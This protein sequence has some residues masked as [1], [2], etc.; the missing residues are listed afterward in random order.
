MCV[1]I[2]LPVIVSGERYAVMDPLEMVWPGETGRWWKLSELSRKRNAL[3]G[4]LG[5]CNFSLGCHNFSDKTLFRFPLR[6][7]RSKLS[8]VNYTL[9]KLWNTLEALRKE[10]KY[11]LLFLRSV[12]TIGVYK[13]TPSGEEEV[14]SVSITEK[15]W[16]RRHDELRQFEEKIKYQFLGRQLAHKVREVIPFTSQFRVV[17]AEQG[18]TEREYEWLVVQQ[19]GSTSEKVLDMVRLFNDRGESVLPWVG[20]AIELSE[21]DQGLKSSRIFCFLP[22]PFEKLSP[23]PVHVNGSFAISK[24]RRSLKW[25]TVERQTDPGAQWNELLTTH[26]LSSCYKQLLVSLTLNKTT[27]LSV[28]Y[29]AWPD[30]SVVNE[31]EW[32][33]L[34][35]PLFSALL[36]EH[37]F[38]SVAEGGQWIKLPDAWLTP[39]NGLPET[40]KSCL[41]ACN[42]KLV[43]TNPLIW[44][45]F[46]FCPLVLIQCISPSFVREVLRLNPGLNSMLDHQQK[47][48]ILL[49]CMSDDDYSGIRG[50]ELLPLA[51]NTFQNFEERDWTDDDDVYLCTSEFPSLLL[52]FLDDRL[53]DVVSFDD[54]QAHFVKLA[55]SGCTQVV[56]VT[57]QSIA[58]LLPQSIANGWSLTNY[59]FFWN[60]IQ[61]H[62][63]DNI[64]ACPV[65]PLIDDSCVITEAISLCSQPKLVFITE[66]DACRLK[67]ELLSAFKKM[68]VM[69]VRQDKLR[70]LYHCEI[71]KY[72]NSLTPDGVL[73]STNFSANIFFTDT[74]SD[75]LL[76]FLASSNISNSSIEVLCRLPIFCTLQ[77]GNNTFFSMNRIADG[78][79]FA[80]AEDNSSPFVI[81]VNLLPIKPLVIAQRA[82]S[83]NTRLLSQLKA[84][85]K[86]SLITLTDFSCKYVFPLIR[87][88]QFPYSKLN[89]FMIVV[90]ELLFYAFSESDRNKMLAEM[91][92]VPFLLNASSVL[93]CP[94]ELFDCNCETAESL[95]KG[96]PVFPMAP[97]DANK[98]SH[99]LRIA[100]LKCEQDVTALNI[101]EIVDQIKCSAVVPQNRGTNKYAR[102]CSV[103]KF[104]SEK[105]SILDERPNRYYYSNDT[106]F[107]D[108]TR[109]YHTTSWLPVCSTP[110]TDYP[111]CLSWKGSLYPNC[112]ASQAAGIAPL[113]QKLPLIA[114]SQLL[115]IQDAARDK[116]TLELRPPKDALVQAVIRHFNEVIRNCLDIDW[117]VREKI[118]NW[119][120]TYLRDNG[121]HT[122]IYF[123]NKKWIWLE[124]RCEFV[125]SRRV[126]LR[127]N[128]NFSS[129]LEPFITILSVK[130]EQFHNLFEKFGV[131]REITIQQILSVLKMIKE[132]AVAEVF[133]TQAWQMVTDILYWVADNSDDIDIEE[134]LVPVQSTNHYP[135]LMPI[136][137]VAYID[138][139]FVMTAATCQLKPCSIVNQRIPSD[140]SKKLRVKPLSE[141]LG[142]S[143]ELPQDVGQQEPLL[144]RLKNILKDYKDGLTIIKELLQNADDAEAT[145]LNIIYD[146]RNHESDLLLFPGMAKAH[147]PAL[148]VH[149]DRTFAEE[150]FENITKLA[151]ATKRDKP[152][153]IGKFGV[154]FCSVYH[155]TDV[156]SF[157][158]GE[159][160]YIFDPTLKHLTVKNPAQ[161]GKKIQ[162][163]STLLSG[164]QQLNP[165]RSIFNYSPGYSYNGTI[166]RLPFRS[167]ESEL[168]SK[169][170]NESDILSLKEQLT[171]EGSK[172]LLFLRHVK[173]ITFSEW[174]QDEQ[175]PQQL[176]IIHKTDGLRILENVQQVKVRINLNIE[177]WLV[178]SCLSKHD[179]RNT[180]QCAAV[181]CKL[182]SDDGCPQVCGES[183]CSLPLGFQTGL[184]VHVSANFAVTSN[185]REIWSS[186]LED[187][188]EDES[189]WNRELMRS[190][191]PDAYS[192]L[193]I[194]LKDLALDEHEISLD[195]YSFHS[196]WPLKEHLQHVNPWYILID[197]LY[198]RISTHALFYSQSKHRWF[199]LSDCTFICPKIFGKLLCETPKCVSRGLEILGEPIVDLPEKFHHYIPE[200]N[201]ISESEFINTFL[202]RIFSF[203]SHSDIRDEII[204]QVLELYAWHAERKIPFN[205]DILAS[206]ACIPCTPNGSLKLCKDL[207]DPTS[208][209]A[210]LFKPKDGF[211]PIKILCDSQPAMRAMRI[212]GLQIETVSYEALAN[213]ARQI[214]S[215]YH[216]KKEKALRNLKL[217]LNCVEKQIEFNHATSSTKR[218]ILKNVPFLPVMQKPENYVLPVWYGEIM[219]FQSPCNLMYG[220]KLPDLVGSQVAIVDAEI[221]QSHDDVLSHIGVKTQ[222][223]VS[224]V[225]TQLRCL[226]E[227]DL[228]T[229]DKD[230]IG[231]TYTTICDFLQKKEEEA[232]FDDEKLD[233][234][235][236]NTLPCVWTGQLFVKP[237]C[238]AK[239]WKCDGPILHPVPKALITKPAL[240]E[241]LGCKDSFSIADLLNALSLL[242]KADCSI[243]LNDKRQE[244]VRE[245]VAD[246]DKFE[247]DEFEMHNE[248]DDL[249]LPD[250]SFVMCKVSDLVFNDVEWDSDNIRIVHGCVT[251]SLAKKL[252]VVFI[253]NKVLRSSE[254]KKF[255]GLPFGQREILQRRI[256]SILRQY[257]FDVTFMKEI[258]QNA[259][260]AKA[261]KLC[262]I[263]DK[264]QLVSRKSEM[265]SDSWKELQG[266]ALLLW[267]NSTFTDKDLQGIQ[268]LGTGGKRGDSD[269][270]GQ[271][272]IG[273]SVVYHVTD[274][275]SIVTSV[276]GV[277][278]LCV[279][280]P[281]CK[282]V[283]EADVLNPGRRYEIGE[284]F[285]KQFPVMKQGYDIDTLDGCPDIMKEQLW[286]GSLFRLPIRKTSEIEDSKSD[287]SIFTEFTADVITT[288]YLLDHIEQWIEDVKLSLLFLNHLTDIEF[289]VINE[290][291]KPQMTLLARHSTTLTE[292]ARKCRNDLECAVNS[293]VSSSSTPKV[294]LYQIYL[295][296]FV[297]TSSPAEE[298][299]ECWLVQ[300]GVG[301]ICL[302]NHQWNFLPNF[303]P[304]HGLAAPLQPGKSKGQVFCFLPLPCSFGLPV[305]INGQFMLGDTRRQLW[306]P[307]DPNRPDDR[308]TWN[309]HL[310]EA[311]GSSYAQF[312]QD[313]IPFFVK[314]CYENYKAAK[315]GLKGYYRIFPT[316][317]HSKS[318]MKKKVLDTVCQQNAKILCS[319]KEESSG[320]QYVTE[321]APIKDEDELNQSYMF[322]AF[323]EPPMAEESELSKEDLK[324]RNEE[325]SKMK[326]QHD[327]LRFLLAKIGMNIN[328]VPSYICRALEIPVANGLEVLKFCKSFPEKIGALPCP[329]EETAISSVG[330]FAA[331]LE[332]V[333]I[334][335]DQHLHVQFV[336][337]HV[338]APFLLTAD[339]HLQLFI[340][341]HR[342]IFCKHLKLF[343]NCSVT[344]HFAHSKMIEMNIDPK[345]FYHTDEDSFDF[346]REILNVAFPNTLHDFEGLFTDTN[347]ANV[348][349][350]TVTNIW[351][352]LT[353]TTVFKHHLKAILKRWALIPSQQ[354]QLFLYRDQ[355]ALPVDICKASLQEELAQLKEQRGLLTEDSDECELN[356]KDSECELNQLQLNLH[357]GEILE[358]LG[359]PILDTDIVS[360]ECIRRACDLPS[361]L[362]PETVLK[363]MKYWNELHPIQ[364]EDVEWRHTLFQFFS[365]VR[366]GNKYNPSPNQDYICSLPLFQ[367]IDR[368][369]SCL[370][371][372]QV[373]VWPGHIELAGLSQWLPDDCVFLE[374]DGKWKNLGVDQAVL[375]IEK[376][377]PLSVYEKFIFP[378]FS[379]LSEADCYKHLEHI[380]NNLLEL[381][382]S[383]IQPLFANS[384][385]VEDEHGKLRCVKKLY[386]S[387]VNLFHTFSSHF[388]FPHKKYQNEEW[389]PFFRKMG[390]QQ[391]VTMIKYEE[392]CRLVE[393]GN[394]EDMHEASAR[395]LKYLFYILWRVEKRRKHFPKAEDWGSSENRDFLKQVFEISFVVIEPL[396]QLNWIVEQCAGTNCVTREGTTYHL[397]KLNEAAISDVADIVWTVRP[398]I[399]LPDEYRYSEQQFKFLSNMGLITQPCLSDVLK[400]VENIVS[401]SKF[402]NIISFDSF[403]VESEGSN[404]CNLLQVMSKSFERL[405]T[406]S[407]EEQDQIR[408][409]LG[410]L[411]CVPVCASQQ[412]WFFL[413]EPQCVIENVEGFQPFLNPLPK[414]LRKFIDVLENIG[415]RHE[416][417]FEHCRYALEKIHQCSSDQRQVDFN[418]QAILEKILECMYAIMQNQSKIADT[419][420]ILYLPSI[421]HK[422]MPSNC[423]V[424]CDEERYRDCRYTVSEDSIVSV[425]WLPSSFRR[426]SVN[427]FCR[428]L[429]ECSQPK[430]FSSHCKQVILSEGLEITNDVT[431]S[432][433]N[434]L[435]MHKT[436]HALESILR[437]SEI[438]PDQCQLILQYFQDVLYCAKVVSIP[439][440]WIKLHYKNVV[441]L[442]AHDQEL[443]TCKVDYFIEEKRHEQSKIYIDSSISDRSSAKF[444]VLLQIA[445]HMVINIASIDHSHLIHI[446]VSFLEAQTEQEIE[447][448]FNSWKMQDSSIPLSSTTVAITP[449]LGAIVP[450]CV[451]HMLDQDV[452]KVFQP[453]EWVAFEEENEYIFARIACP[454]RNEIGRM[455]DNIYDHRYNIIALPNHDVL[456]V[457]II[458]LYKFL[459]SGH[460]HSQQPTVEAAAGG[461]IER[462][463]Q[464]YQDEIIERL[465]QLSR[466]DQNE[467]QII[468][469]RLLLQWHPDKNLEYITLAQRVHGF[470]KDVLE[471]RELCTRQTIED[472]DRI[473][474]SHRLHS[475]EDPPIYHPFE[476]SCE[477]DYREAR[478]WLEQAKVDKAALDVLLNAANATN[479]LFGHVCFM[480]HEV[481]EKALKAGMYA[482]HGRRTDA[483]L[484]DHHI[485]PIYTNIADKLSDESCR[486]LVKHLHVLRQ[487][488]YYL[489]TRFP[490]QWYYSS[491][492]NHFKLKQAEDAQKIAED[493]I[494]TVETLIPQA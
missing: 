486:T 10:A 403:N 358:N 283:P 81:G 218:E 321:W 381:F 425:L 493:F 70:F 479:K 261:T 243:T 329:I 202:N 430:P 267:N 308:S 413:V 231:R 294:V 384:V 474:Y 412:N 4:V 465:D 332:Y 452:E 187:N 230:A 377:H 128:N 103:M 383:D 433:Q 354:N 345:Y 134:V 178:S 125:E 71:L 282:Y 437:D 255:I 197:E 170:Y 209:I 220:P 411:Q 346:V 420:D 312:L 143:A 356:P 31:S 26:C 432:L 133:P 273:F 270:I 169:S 55:N 297:C 216:R 198:E 90:M 350:S 402:G 295:T 251:I 156:P 163:T 56:E 482:V 172:L 457:S 339:H 353:R 421:H 357:V 41:V 252:R 9:T 158:S 265:I 149:N 361:V 54:L 241:S 389:L 179:K 183:F 97:F 130:Y 343:S 328:S 317:H 80:L 120:Y 289:Y 67:P 239:N 86:I 221:G 33:G 232:L 79:S 213:C 494:R 271:F 410:S 429:P 85:R 388:L 392:L 146:S 229:V 369:L 88:K 61:P 57:M 180:Y 442:E 436:I 62:S 108:L 204:V 110:P 400:N 366:F 444:K 233:L 306:T 367:N 316:Y 206:T 104:L 286:K 407:N 278:S 225:I 153:K 378:K 331:L 441:I 162:C 311:I 166:F 472:C 359:M 279:F 394:H 91:R 397:T 446:I 157:V 304:R 259:D 196:L 262:V 115:F 114:G 480:A 126:A 7:H 111:T 248:R 370:T 374:E 109:L 352:C 93:K 284:S 303:K 492:A 164:S 84:R 36:H 290:V 52:P 37:V 13:I 159:W 29:A 237:D 173:K 428:F 431:Q 168:S 322:P 89:G 422:L 258:L 247:D 121:D 22:M 293:F 190:A 113:T 300:E 102:A 106:L 25:P 327:K 335:N 396:P 151:G 69:L 342:V 96:E 445:Q 277:S 194:A 463:T 323:I 136:S 76:T 409:S 355:D 105:P 18:M 488:K 14:F 189:Q 450:E 181:A 372:K 344:R 100:G 42:I 365:E 127:P 12:Q 223:E 250:T 34:L 272:G 244:L 193:L 439:K 302:P 351:K 382:Q 249:A 481:A 458:M 326:E 175:F 6:K 266:P 238:V 98:Y 399:R 211:F 23:L 72:I 77:Y 314:G 490:N 184:P 177:E 253:R 235:D 385:C 78:K 456:C 471:T 337:D 287:H 336:D 419:T 424:Y 182:M 319:V 274:C 491:P 135:V 310:L 50:L 39:E 17:V 393:S 390:M 152:L 11:L 246:L 94:N 386:D 275:P 141:Y 119:T 217:I 148:I 186:I 423:L 263:L 362:K 131:P 376:I 325:I 154:G 8:D 447:L 191:I 330:N 298:S 116:L 30:P 418:T 73:T 75:A 228:T 122:G 415:V 24:D 236:L 66:S 174:K 95:Y 15:D 340:K 379:K 58:S 398:V 467:Q 205:N 276:G 416:L 475:K 254:A 200:M 401:C 307:S 460:T 139:D 349:P 51:N 242:Y 375:C 280:D 462:L 485:E 165:Y 207:V 145:E 309:D 364:P 160:L 199:H 129:N 144:Q 112:L 269:T 195:E 451:H 176:V 44:K 435:C 434:S 227:I 476:T 438:S 440:L 40:V 21:P 46:H 404:G 16:Q 449:K 299:K 138:S 3:A 87:Q 305:H 47:L 281:L 414:E 192:Q 142:V 461:Q 64:R 315:Y 380:K 291:K 454:N 68:G 347:T 489:K 99:L 19:V 348:L 215:L 417:D 395:L 296:S 35:V 27:S 257:P 408:K 234:S 137:E 371:G 185:R 469:R 226:L 1:C 188:S 405:C 150:D 167:C 427:K 240:Q 256:S 455:P 285:W 473:A 210:E 324:K 2:D 171:Q 92:T 484:M 301:D 477:P 406:S 161:P 65:V 208:S 426:T 264:R 334:D 48:E 38:Y 83:N 341:E 368:S 117:D 140:L 333:C 387:S 313:A 363:N 60:W 82:F 214:P 59:Q 147:G 360:N 260:D 487:G 45:I 124:N 464:I 123:L 63:L 101:C 28:S 203:S 268:D 466:F 107:D 443:A 224:T 459:R 132:K 448:I 338:G 118:V 470:L 212:L 453:G 468:I 373:Y 391:E 20:T 292:E 43:N 53:I 288:E 74:E 32:K 483:Y 320:H 49:Y 478:C 201:F 219:L 155:I 222:P 245:I 5:I 318:E